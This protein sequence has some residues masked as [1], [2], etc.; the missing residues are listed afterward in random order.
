[1]KFR[2]VYEPSERRDK[3]CIPDLLRPGL[4]RLGAHLD[5][6]IRHSRKVKQ[7]HFKD[8]KIKYSNKFVKSTQLKIQN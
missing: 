2:T 7:L 3:R 6:K 5:R 1:M 8:F 4:V